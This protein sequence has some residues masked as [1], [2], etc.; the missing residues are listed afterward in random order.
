[1]PIHFANAD[2]SFRLHRCLDYLKSCKSIGCTTA[3]IQSYTGSMAPH[4][5]IAELRANGYLIERIR[6]PNTRSG[7]QVHRYTFKGRRFA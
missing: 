6:E 2:K 5:D 1:M 4:T 3:E 7:R